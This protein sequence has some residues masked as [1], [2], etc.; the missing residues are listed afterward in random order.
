MSVICF[1]GWPPKDHLATPKFSVK[2]I[3]I[4]CRIVNDAL[5]VLVKCYNETLIAAATATR[6]R[7]VYLD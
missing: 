3:F 6:D 2:T 5:I 1:F 7:L 4:P